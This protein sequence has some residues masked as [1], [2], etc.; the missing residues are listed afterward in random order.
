V[1]TSPTNIRPVRRAPATTPKRALKRCVVQQAAFGES[2][3]T[4]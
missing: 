3:G 1:F 4:S 2:V